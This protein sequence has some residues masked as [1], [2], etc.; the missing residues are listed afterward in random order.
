M[1]MPTVT[2]DDATIDAQFQTVFQHKESEC[3]SIAAYK[4]LKVDEH[5][6]YA[7]TVASLV[8]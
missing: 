5:A 4:T 2:R 8:T 7:A 1:P 3:P 6:E